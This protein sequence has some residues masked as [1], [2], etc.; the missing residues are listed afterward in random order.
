VKEKFDHINDDLLV[1]YLLN[2]ATADEQQQV[3]QWLD[4]DAANLTYY[5]ELKKIWEQS[6][7]LAA[8]TTVDENR[9]WKKF[10]ATIHPAEIKHT[11]FGWVRFAAAIIL[12]AGIGFVSYLMVNNRVHEITLVA[13]QAVLNDTL[14]D[15]S[16]VTVNTGS[17][18]SYPSE[19]KKGTR[20]VAL[21]G[22]AFFTVTPNKKKPFIISVNDVQITVVGTSFNVKNINGNTE[23]AVESGI[24]KVQ[25][26]GKIVELRA[27]E[28]ILVDAKD[29]M[30]S[31]EKLTDHLYN[32]YRT[33]EFVCDD[34][35]LWKLVEVI[36]EA[37]HSHVV[38]GNPALRNMSLTTT[39]HNE[40]LDQ[41]LNVIS[42]TFNI[43]LVKQGD[44]IILQ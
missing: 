19:F 5:N 6:R 17:S 42:I 11:G 40:S 32:Y 12:I 10:Q 7:Q 15:G 18:I 37:Y 43:R 28:K 29:S 30:F 39:F 44:T 8:T 31:K 22:E 34:T 4:A 9:A 14:P 3:T 25:R 21:K 16:I 27:N 35:P 20:P 13:Q 41:V 38:I 33:K 2:E 36:N 26:A 24:V 23:V 1:K